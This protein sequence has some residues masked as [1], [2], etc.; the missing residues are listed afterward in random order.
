MTSH[1]LY[2]A[3][4]NTP[5]NFNLHHSS[6]KISLKTLQSWDFCAKQNQIPHSLWRAAPPDPL[7]QR[8][9]TRISSSLLGPP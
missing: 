6:L 3:A 9:N 4:P 7:L 8:Y 2:G 5:P 1:T